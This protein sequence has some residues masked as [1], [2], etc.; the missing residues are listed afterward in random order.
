MFVEYAL[1]LRASTISSVA[2]TSALRITSNEIGST[3]AVTARAVPSSLPRPPRARDGDA[4]HV[5]RALGAHLALEHVAQH[6]RG[7]ALLR[8]PVAASAAGAVADDVARLDGHGRLG[9]QPGLLAPADQH[10]L[11]DSTVVAAEGAGR[12]GDGAI[13]EDGERRR[14]IEEE[15]LAQPEPAAEATRPLGVLDERQPVDAHRVVELRLLD[16]RVLGVL[17]MRLHGVR[18]VARVAAAVAAAERLEEADVL[19]RGAVDASEAG[20]AHHRLRPRRQRRRESREQ[21]AE[22]HVDEA[23]LRL[24]AADDR[25]GPGA[26]RHR[27]A[28]GVER[29]EPVEAVV[30]REVGV[31]Q[32]LERVRAGGEGLGVG[33]VDRRPALRVAAGEV[34][35]DAASG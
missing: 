10:V 9:R 11:G 23:G 17:P 24:P 6:A 22:D 32:A 30:D 13:R 4:V 8:R 18:P 19:V 1:R 12:P 34:E 33:R 35:R 14:P 20:V 21:G 31:D 5:P 15:V 27:S 26:V 28:R 7:I 29:D 2:A 25:R 16:G 3:A